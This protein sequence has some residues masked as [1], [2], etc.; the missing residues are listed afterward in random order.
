MPETRDK[1]ELDG[2]PLDEQPPAAEP[3]DEE[4]GWETLRTGLGREWDFDKEGP[5]VGHWVGIE[6]VP[7]EA[8][9]RK[10]ARAHTFAVIPTGEMVFVWSSYELEAA[11]EQAGTGDK[12]RIQFLGRDSFTG[13]DGPRQVKRFKV[14][15]ATA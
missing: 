7:V 4:A 14:Q 6:E 15:R 10:T 13:D 1:Q 12:L 11:L 5:L 3:V 2:Q 9:D 8:S